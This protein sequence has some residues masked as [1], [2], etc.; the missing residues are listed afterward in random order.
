MKTNLVFLDPDSHKTLLILAHTLQALSS[1]SLGVL[2][3]TDENDK[4]T[5]WQL[6]D[7][8]TLLAMVLPL[9]IHESTKTEENA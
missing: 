5:H 6:M 3:K 8:D 9:V 4:I 2:I 7:I 1:C